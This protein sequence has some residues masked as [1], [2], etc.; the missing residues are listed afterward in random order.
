MKY[1]PRIRSLVQANQSLRPSPDVTVDTA[2]FE[3]LSKIEPRDGFDY[4]FPY[5]RLLQWPIF[6]VSDEC[7]DYAFI[8]LGLNVVDIDII[9]P[10]PSSNGMDRTIE[11]LHSRPPPTKS[12]SLQTHSFDSDATPAMINS[13]LLALSGS[14][15]RVELEYPCWHLKEW[16]VLR[17][18]PNLTSLWIC[19]PIELEDKPTPFESAFPSLT[20]LTLQFQH[21]E[22]LLEHFLDHFVERRFPRLTSLT[23]MYEAPDD[24]IVAIVHNLSRICDPQVLET[25]KITHWGS[26]YTEIDDEQVD[27]FADTLNPLY[28]YSNLRTVVI[29]PMK[30]MDLD[31][32]TIDRMA[33]AWPKIESLAIRDPWV[34]PP[35]VTVWGLLPLARHCPNLHILDITINGCAIIPEEALKEVQD[36]HWNSPLRSLHLASSPIDSSLSHQAR[37]IAWYLGNIFP[38]LH[39]VT[40]GTNDKDCPD[41]T[42]DWSHVSSSIQSGELSEIPIPEEV[43]APPG[44]RPPL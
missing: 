5:I 9:V 12:L 41:P 38:S 13:I 19:I 43:D 20:E 37:T 6:G 7:I 23:L 30:R 16:T 29:Q 35:K 15:T 25:I 21:G 4:L 27:V 26:S 18:L 2:V 10:D 8:F 40:W 14:L 22:V 28:A 17:V 42:N 11:K 32:S 24:S 44:E 34:F 33:G 39:Q 31:N 3:A 1:A 36:D